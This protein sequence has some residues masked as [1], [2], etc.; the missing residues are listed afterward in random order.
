[1]AREL[2]ALAVQG[3]EIPKDARFY[4]FRDSPGSLLQKS[5]GML[6][7]L[8]DVLTA[9]RKVADANA[10]AVRSDGLERL[11][12]MLRAE[13]TDDYLETVAA[14][15]RELRFPKGV[16]VSAGLGRA[17]RGTGYVLH[18]PH[19]SSLLDRITSRG[20]AGTTFEIPERDEHG[21]QAL[22]DLQ[23]RG[24]GG[25]AAA[26]A[27]ATDQIIGFF[28]QLRE[29]LG[30]FVCCLNLSDGLTA[31]GVTTCLPTPEREDAGGWSARG[32]CDAALPFHLEGPVV[33]SDLAGD[34]ADLI[35]VTGANNGGKST[36]LRSLGIAQAMM[37][38]GMFVTAEA[39]RASTCA[40]VFTHFRQEEDPATGRGGLE[41]ELQRMSEIGDEIT[42]GALL[43]CNESFAAT[44]EREGSE[45]ARQ[46]VRAMTEVG[47]RVVI[48][49]HLYELADGLHHDPVARTL[50][51]RAE[52][53]TDGRRTFRMLA[54]TPR[55]T[56]HAQDSY[57]RAFGHG[58]SLSY[59]ATNAMR[60]ASTRPRG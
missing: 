27:D 31:L 33:G 29:E 2:Y 8:C 47:V 36:F 1:M 46:V 7:A 12:R 41:D 13:L 5:V 22:A 44:N 15:L 28:A 23:A 3:V 39:F 52:R 48:V 11:F 37:Q 6:A 56:S 51:L 25:L 18:E 45:I 14:R 10:G 30:F 21:M 54:G 58:P 4:W 34:D 24:I 60:L 59:D 43:L 17:N 38:A 40:G 50:H 57:Q 19:R 16:L 49:T 53:R 55:R 32:L 20:P 42:P 9:V 35:V 26:L